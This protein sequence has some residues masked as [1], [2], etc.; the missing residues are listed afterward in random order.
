MAVFGLG[1][2]KYHDFLRTFLLLGDCAGP[3]SVDG[4]SSFAELL[5]G[6]SHVVIE[7]LRKKG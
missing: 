1:R 5:I 6:Y 2:I 7:V 4:N 3:D